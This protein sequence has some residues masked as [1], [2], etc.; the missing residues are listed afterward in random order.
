M[1]VYPNQ[2]DNDLD[3]P[4]IEDNLSQIGGLVIN[5]LR[6]ST[7]A[8]EET[9]GTNPQGTKGTVVS[10]L[11]V[12]HNPDGTLKSS[13]L[14][15]AGLVTLPITNSQIAAGAG[16]VESK[17]TLNYSTS[18]LNA[19]ISSLSSTVSGM[20][21]V[22]TELLTDF[23]LHI[24]GLTSP[25]VSDGYVNR[26]VASHVDINNGEFNGYPKYTGVDPRD[27]AYNNTGLYDLDGNIRNARTIMDALLQINNDFLS[28]ALSTSS[29]KHVATFIS[30]DTS[31]FDL[32][33]KDKTN[34]QLAL[35]YLDDYET[36]IFDKHRAEQHSNGIPRAS[37]VERYENDGYNTIL[38]VFEC[39]ASTT[40]GGLGQLSFTV[41]P[42]DLDWAFRQIIP[43][44]IIQV[45][46]GG[47]VADHTIDTITYVPNTTYNIT[48]DG[49]LLNTV[50]NIYALLKKS[51]YD[52]NHYGALAVV[53]A[54]HNFYNPP[55]DAS[56]PGS[57]IVV[58]PN[59]ATATGVDFSPDDL[60]ST[61]YM[62]YIGYYP[63]GDPSEVNISAPT[64]IL[65]ID[66]TGNLGITPGKYSLKHVIETT[67]KKFRSGGYN[68]RFV[69]FEYKGQFG[70][71][72]AD[73]VDN[74]AFSIISGVA[75]GTALSPGSFMFNVVGDATTP[76]KDP[77]GFGITKA[78][79]ASPLYQDPT[80]TSLPTKVITRKVNRKYNIDGQY[81]DYLQK[82]HLTNADGYYDGYFKERQAVG[83]TRAR[84]IYRVSQDLSNTELKVGSTIVV[85]PAVDRSDST[86]KEQDYGRF[87]VED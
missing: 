47:Y 16:I 26:H 10:F 83:L 73:V 59:C 7:F 48:I 36:E 8:I 67:N 64:S 76:I 66:V 57:A 17:L 5:A 60:D 80:A 46:Y 37:K 71:A 41:V 11:N 75:S 44:D 21:N 84:G 31:S 43:G 20:N 23:T 13:A 49:Y 52:D 19:A 69:A 35:D 2:I 29:T 81:I 87:I 15:S 39:S 9:L 77:L 61:H 68:Y 45:N 56:V 53:S 6:D 18:V 25:T 62:L 14:T 12:S 27:S 34:V 82:G 78:N 63:T 40:V 65:G 74:A 4:L 54:N 50:S 51:Q 28:H 85:Y 86:F 70:I 72:L 1:T 42:G 55:N 58:S 24:Y 33:P 30:V 32:I 79:I 38:G 22:L 3:L